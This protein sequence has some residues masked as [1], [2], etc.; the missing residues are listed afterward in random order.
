MFETPWVG[1]LA[2]AVALGL[3][4]YRLWRFAIVASCFAI[5]AASPVWLDAAPPRI[6]VYVDL[7]PSTR[8]AFWRD[9]QTLSR[10]LAAFPGEPELFVF[11]EVAMRTGIEVYD[12]GDLMAE[13]TKLD[14][15][16]DADAAVVLTDGRLDLTTVLP[17]SFLIDPALDA[18]G[19]AAAMSLE[20]D[21]RRVLRTWREN[22]R[23]LMQ[24]TESDDPLAVG[25]DDAW[26]ENDRLQLPPPPPDGGRRVIF[27]STLPSFVTLSS[28]TFP[29]LASADVVVLTTGEL[30]RQT[31]QAIRRY[32]T[33]LGGSLVLATTD[34]PPTALEALLPL[35][36]VP[37][38]PSGRWAFLLDASGSMRDTW[39]AVRR[40]TLAAA[41]AL[42]KNARVDL[43]M[44]SADVTWLARDAQATELPTLPDAT[45]GPTNLAAAVDAVAGPRQVLVVTDAAAEVAQEVID[46][47]VNAAVL[48][49]VLHTGDAVSPSVRR[50]VEQTGGTLTIEPDEAAWRDAARRLTRNASAGA[51]RDTP[52]TLTLDDVAIEV[53]RWRQAWATTR[54]TVL[55]DEPAA[56]SVRV[57]AGS[58]VAVAASL[59]TDALQRIADANASQPA[60]EY[61]VR[62]SDTGVLTVEVFDGPGRFVLVHGDERIDAEQVSLTHWRATLAGRRE[63]TIAAV[64]YGDEVLS[65]QPTADRY[66]SEFDVIG[67]AR[68]RLAGLADAAGGAVVADVSQLRHEGRPRRRPLGWLFLLLAGVSAVALAEQLRRGGRVT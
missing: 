18:P 25:G 43:A 50:L 55:C 16:V 27:G 49:H 10:V 68:E 5:A 8:T 62:W 26:P 53:T 3:L 29:D 12:G 23:E 33:D 7:S 63:A 36:F 66:A 44:F 1:S 67:N 39:P 11:G 38:G 64:L 40:A 54:A 41:E 13:Q 32:V 60:G 9:P 30:D 48:V 56:A 61:D 35:S 4:V 59:P 65:R 57:G 14:I 21:G 34:L 6:A 42:P 2:G 28:A 19:D 31:A 24:V 58:V 51:I 45:G 52:A 37:P 22:G 15:N 17:T 20:R 46:R 47:A